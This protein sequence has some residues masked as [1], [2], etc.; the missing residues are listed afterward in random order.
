[1]SLMRRRAFTLIELLVVIAII[2]VL[3]ALL[4]PAVQAAREAARRSQCVNNLK[5]LG[6]AFHNY[7]DLNQTFPDARPGSDANQNDS[8]AMSNW[9]SMLP[10]YEQQALFNAWNFSLTFNDPS[11]AGPPISLTCIPLANT[12]VAGSAISVFN[13]PSDFRQ[14][15]V[16]TVGS[17]RNDIPHVANLA[18]SSYSVCVGTGG[19]PS[20]CSD[21]GPPVAIG[22]IKHNNNGFADYG[23]PRSTADFQDGTSNTLCTG[24][25]SYSSDGT[26]QTPSGLQTNLATGGAGLFNVWTI[27]LRNSSNFH[28]SKNPINTQPNQGIRVPTGNLNVVGQNGAFGSRHPGGANFL[29]ADGHVSFLKNTLNQQVFWAISTRNMGEVVSG[30]SY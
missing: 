2:A 13:C 4:L 3:I 16:S 18:V 6:L 1:M 23:A 11:V 9:V 24:E 12:T 15:T 22:D 17:G 28:S 20:C 10:E 29:W 7:H 26:F 5:Q 30:D 25:V 14:S 19:P 8:N 27:T 21:S